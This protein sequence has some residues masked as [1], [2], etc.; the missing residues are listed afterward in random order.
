MTR[1]TRV[2]VVALSTLEADHGNS[3]NLGPPPE[4]FIIRHGAAIRAERVNY[5]ST[6]RTPQG[7]CTRGKP[8]VQCTSR[9]AEASFS[10]Y[11]SAPQPYH[12][13]AGP[14]THTL[15]NYSFQCRME[16]G[17][18]HGRGFGRGKGSLQ[19]HSRSRLYSKLELMSRVGR[20]RNGMMSLFLTC[21]LQDTASL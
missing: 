3:L 21:S 17:I 6:T 11:S 19:G 16:L 8:S 20:I 12:V 4:A 1:Q 2:L 10:S 9:L 5:N 18:G 13:Q 15:S 7:W 14:K